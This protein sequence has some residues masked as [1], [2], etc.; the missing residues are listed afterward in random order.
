MHL[1]QCLTIYTM[2]DEGNTIAHYIAGVAHGSSYSTSPR[3]YIKALSAFE[4]HGGNLAALNSHQEN[5]LHSSIDLFPIEARKMALEAGCDPM[6]K[7]DKGISP[8]DIA[9]ESYITRRHHDREA[10]LDLINLYKQYGAE[11][12][13]EQ[14]KK[15][16]SAA[17]HKTDG[18]SLYL[19]N[20]KRNPRNK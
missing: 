20:N 18:I 2:D 16:E 9:V 12:T 11:L 8:L 19:M 4:K 15:M 7:N 6:Q 3:G 1:M 5:I 10:S 13:G 14:K 17:P